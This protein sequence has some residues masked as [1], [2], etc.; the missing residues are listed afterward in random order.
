MKAKCASVC[1]PGS[2]HRRS[3]GRTC[4]CM[5]KRREG[6]LE[7]PVRLVSWSSRRPSSRW[8]CRRTPPSPDSA[9]RAA[10]G[11]CR[12]FRRP[13]CLG[14]RR[15]GRA[16]WGPPSPAGWMEGRPPCRPARFRKGL[17]KGNRLAAG[18]GPCYAPHHGCRLHFLPWA[19]VP[20]AR[21]FS[22]GRRRLCRRGAVIL[23]R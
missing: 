4:P 16:G 23:P 17:G 14:Q 18:V 21:R 6:W 3:A 15:G 10:R 11:P 20:A 7:T 12:T 5:A 19:A 2:P 1:R 8:R 9:P 22:P 13:A